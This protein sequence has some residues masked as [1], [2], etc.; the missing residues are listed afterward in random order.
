M[1]KIRKSLQAIPMLM[2]NANHL[3]D[4]DGNIKS[5]LSINKS[6]NTSPLTDCSSNPSLGEDP[7]LFDSKYELLEKL[8]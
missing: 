7:D 5:S 2:V 4:A 8:G 1:T 6:G 3:K